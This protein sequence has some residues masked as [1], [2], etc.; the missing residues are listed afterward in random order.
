MFDDLLCIEHYDRR[1]KTLSNFGMDSEALCLDINWYK[2]F[3]KNISYVINQNGFRDANHDDFQNHYF[4]IGDS[5]TFGLGQPYE[6]TWP[7]Q[8]ENLLNAPV[9]KLA[10][11]GASNDWIRLVVDRIMQFK[12][13]AIF[14]MLS[15]AHRELTFNN[16]YIKHLQYNEEH[17]KDLKWAENMIE[18]TKKHLVEIQ[19]I[20]KQ[21][22]TPVF[23]TA[24]PYFDLISTSKEIRNILI[25]YR[26]LFS[27][28]PLQV[29]QKFSDLARD[30]LHFGQKTS[31]EVATN[32]YN[33]YTK[34]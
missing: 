27:A 21:S 1:G 8:L 34:G 20:C 26:R 30:G 31:N 12:P 33:V 18:K 29:Y 9:I 22:D 14:I 24:V 11:D 13:K 7:V 23:F 17:F 28:A 32:F 3:S 4:A 19:S 10:C 6:E 25:P 16:D 5:F 15:F 2:S